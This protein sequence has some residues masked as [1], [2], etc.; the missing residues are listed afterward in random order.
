MKKIIETK[1]TKENSEKK[2]KIQK[3]QKTKETKRYPNDR[4]IKNRETIKETTKKPRRSGRPKNL[5]KKQMN[6]KKTK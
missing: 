3:D 4:K 2:Q 5:K 6:R 1:G